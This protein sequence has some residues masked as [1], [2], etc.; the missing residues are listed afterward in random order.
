MKRLATLIFPLLWVIFCVINC[1]NSNTGLITDN[2]GIQNDDHTFSDASISGYVTRAS[3]GAPVE[4]V[5][6]LIQYTNGLTH[7]CSEDYTDSNGYYYCSME[8]H[9]HNDVIE[10]IVN[11]PIGSGCYPVLHNIY[12]GEE[13]PQVDY[14][15]PLPPPWDSFPP[16]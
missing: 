12:Y 8:G 6:V 10:I 3:N 16:Q 5:H 11:P 14:E 9:V 4:N 1:S 2:T 7:I 13:D 15:C